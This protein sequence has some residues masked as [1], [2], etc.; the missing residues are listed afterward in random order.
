MHCLKWGN[1]TLVF[2]G[3]CCSTFIGIAAFNA[4]FIDLLVSAALGAFLVAVQVFI[5]ARSDILSSVFEI[6]ITTV[7][8]L[9]SMPAD[10][11]LSHTI[12]I[13]SF[14][15]AGL[16]STEIFCYAAITSSSIVLI[17]PGCKIPM[18][19]LAFLPC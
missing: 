5:A 15:A 2:F 19:S 14:T 9:R 8:T 3:A 6:I 11:M 16:A 17:L 1:W 7:S 18:S 10:F 4:S 12:Q 13:I